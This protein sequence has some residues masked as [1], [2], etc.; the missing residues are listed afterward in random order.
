MSKTITTN[1]PTST[2]N[3]T[4]TVPV[5]NWESD[6]RPAVDKAGEAQLVS[7]SSPLDA[8]ADYTFKSS[9]I[10]N[11]YKGSGT[12][13]VG[14]R[15]GNST[16]VKLLCQKNEIWSITDSNDAT[17]KVNK[18]VSAHLVLN[19]P[20]DGLITTTNVTDL[21]NRMIGGLYETVDSSG[22]SRLAAMLRQALMPTGM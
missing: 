8:A 3:V 14:L 4:L 17:Y 18:P 20:N 12:I 19:I 21:I 1:Q 13:P 7:I 11:I 22:T 6:Y 9:I 15:D 2:V 16:G 10:P 5:P